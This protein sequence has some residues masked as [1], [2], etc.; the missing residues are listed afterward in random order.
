MAKTSELLRRRP[1]QRAQRN[2][3]AS[4]QVIAMYFFARFNRSSK[5]STRANEQ[6][7][8]VS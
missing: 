4:V 8:H 3:G 2:E 1:K 7:L 6:R 5:H